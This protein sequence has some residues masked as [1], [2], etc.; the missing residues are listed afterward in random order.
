M[1]DEK[2]ELRSLLI[3][4]D[5][6]RQSPKYH[7]EGDALFHSLQV[8]ELAQRATDD[9]VLWA[10]ALFHDVG[11]AVDGPLHDEVGADL[12][13][14]LLP[15]RAVWLVRHHLDLLKD[16]R[17]ARRRYLGTPAL[18]DLEQLRRWDLGGRDPN[19]RVMSVD[20]AFDVLFSAEPSLLEPGDDD[21][22]HGSF[23]PERP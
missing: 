22:E 3:A 7:P 18:R 1:K 11:K 15:A 4:L 5:G 9:P 19:A 6:I 12:L 14:G 13:E 21:S 20:D 10:A 8:F 2:D 16:P 17:A 23:D